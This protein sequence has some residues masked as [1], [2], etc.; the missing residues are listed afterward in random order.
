[1]PRSSFRTAS[2]CA[3]KAEGRKTLAHLGHPGRQPNLRVCQKPVSRR[4]IPDHP[5]QRFG[6][7]AAADPHLV[8]ACR[9]YLDVAP[10]G[11]TKGAFAS[12]TNPSGGKRAASENRD[13]AAILTQIGTP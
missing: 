10:D 3:T 9:L 1:M 12:K 5:C 2:A 11:T 4:Q 8:P 6:I 13:H 7:I